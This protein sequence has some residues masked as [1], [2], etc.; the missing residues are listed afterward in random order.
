[1]I[2]EVWAGTAVEDNNVKL[3]D[4]LLNEFLTKVSSKSGI[5]LTAAQAAQLIANAQSLMK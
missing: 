2:R 3:G 4:T 1:M 5:S